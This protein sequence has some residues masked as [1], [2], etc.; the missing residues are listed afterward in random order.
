[1]PPKKPFKSKSKVKLG[2]NPENSQRSMGDFTPENSPER[3]P[4]ESLKLDDDKPTQAEMEAQNS[5]TAKQDQ[6]GNK[7]SPRKSS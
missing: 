2:D 3:P 4:V 1:M 7:G 5:P 6:L